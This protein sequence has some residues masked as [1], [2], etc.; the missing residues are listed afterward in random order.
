MPILRV[1]RAHASA[2]VS[3]RHT[4]LIARVD[5]SY[6]GQ[7]LRPVSRTEET[8]RA[9][10][11]EPA[12]PNS[13]ST[14][15]FFTF[16]RTRQQQTRLRERDGCANPLRQPGVGHFVAF[17]YAV[18]WHRCRLTATPA[19]SVRDWGWGI[20]Q[21]Y[22]ATPYQTICCCRS[23]PRVPLLSDVPRIGS[24]CLCSHSPCAGHSAGSL[25]TVSG[26]IQGHRSQQG[27]TTTRG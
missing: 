8:P 24:R 11:G 1:L 27:S 2:R 12:D 7:V 9:A 14:L 20:L 4:W 22:G 19:D 16:V 21:L 25:S 23:E 18:A 10:A 17:S 13:D 3:G 6:A 5:Y 15:A 26:I